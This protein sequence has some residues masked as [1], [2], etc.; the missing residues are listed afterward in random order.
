M[1]P[2]NT[3]MGDFRDKVAAP[4][5]AAARADADSE[6]GGA[7]IP[8]LAEAADRRQA[9]IARTAIPKLDRNRAVSAGKASPNQKSHLVSRTRSSFDQTSCSRLVL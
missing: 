2:L 3:D 6:A 8:G 4:D 7:P 1:A 9:T 5:P